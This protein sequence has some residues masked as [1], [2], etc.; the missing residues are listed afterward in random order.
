[1]TI[2]LKFF[3][4]GV[5]EEGEDQMYRLKFTKKRGN[6][7]EWYEMQQELNEQ[8]FEGVIQETAN[9]EAVPVAE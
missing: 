3:K 6:I 1:L 7:M 2:K 4:Q 9:K 5:P 8:A